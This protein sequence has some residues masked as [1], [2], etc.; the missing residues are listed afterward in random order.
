M[1]LVSP[2]PEK[3]QRLFGLW[4]WRLGGKYRPACELLAAAARMH[5]EK[6]YAVRS[7]EP[8]VREGCGPGWLKRG[9]AA[10]QHTQVTCSEP[11]HF[12]PILR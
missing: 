8:A 6:A 10:L 3:T 7:L 1:L 11:A 12:P 4:Y 2:H 9:V 5:A